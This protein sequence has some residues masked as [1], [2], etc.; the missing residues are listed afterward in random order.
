MFGLFK[1]QPRRVADLEAKLTSSLD[2]EVTGEVELECFSDESY[3]LEIEISHVTKPLH[4][5]L[6]LSIDGRHVGTFN[7]GPLRTRFRRTREDGPLGFAPIERQSVRILYD[8][9]TLLQGSFRRD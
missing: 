9:K 7:P 5:P 6:T 3:L 4:H 8:G 1:S 2:S